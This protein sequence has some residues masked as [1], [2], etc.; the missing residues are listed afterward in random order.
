MS[1]KVLIFFSYILLF[2]SSDRSYGQDEKFIRK[3]FK[4]QT[5]DL[6]SKG[7]GRRRFHWVVNGPAHNVDFNG[8]GFK[9]KIYISK[10][11]QQDWIVVANS[12]NKALFEGVL[13]PVGRG[14]KIYKIN[15]TSLNSNVRVMVLHY[16]EGVTDYIHTRGTSRLYFVSMDYNNLDT[17]SLFKGPIVW[18]EKEEKL[19]HYHQRLYDLKFKDYNNDGLKEV[20][21]SYNHIGQVYF[22]K[23]GGNWQL[24]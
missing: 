1:H 4:K 12:D 17:L 7:L 20:S 2:W 10:R 19:G 23:G 24:L 11:D 14:S 21:V 22:Y 13:N 5:N 8:D 3:V 16:F 9:E 6:F 18:E 15:M